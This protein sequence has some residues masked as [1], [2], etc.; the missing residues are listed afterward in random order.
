VK[1]GYSQALGNSPSAVP[2]TSPSVIIQ[3]RMGPSGGP[4]DRF[5]LA[6][7]HSHR[8]MGEGLR[9]H[10]SGTAWPGDLHSTQHQLLASL[11]QLATAAV[12]EPHTAGSASFFPSCI[13]ALRHY[14]KPSH[15]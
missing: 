9:M 11:F 14:S 13:V 15:K 1:P 10:P 5:S 12:S 3:G 2:Y 8:E 4:Q 6:D 7:T